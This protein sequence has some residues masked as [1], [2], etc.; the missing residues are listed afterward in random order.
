MKRG[1]GP[2]LIEGEQR[3]L[4]ETIVSILEARVLGDQKSSV[5][6][7]ETIYNGRWADI[8]E[9]ILGHLRRTSKPPR[10][11]LASTFMEAAS[12]DWPVHSK[13]AATEVRNSIKIRRAAESDSSQFLSK[14]LIGI[15]NDPFN[16]SPNCDVIQKWFLKRENHCGSKS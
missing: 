16:T 10:V 2:K 1:D 12:R 5:I 14:C 4:T 3:G 8:A 7:P 11:S 9:K 15:F 6:I 13:N